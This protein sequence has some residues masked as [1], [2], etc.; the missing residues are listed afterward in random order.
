LLARRA[1]AHGTATPIAPSGQDHL[2]LLAIHQLYTRPEFR[3]SDLHCAIEA[4]RARTLDWDYVF[5]TALSTGIVPAVGCYVQYL[6]R[7]HE[8]VT[9]R[10]L[11]PQPVLD[12]LCRRAR[13]PSA[14]RGRRRTLAFHAPGPQRGCTC[15]T[16]APRS[17]RAAG[18]A[19]A[20]TALS[21]PGAGRSDRRHAEEAGV[22]AKLLRLYHSLPARAARLRPRCVA[23]T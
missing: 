18:Q 14:R 5:A 7:V 17:N 9:G 16:S 10:A 15:K 11:L 4:V 22:N 19:S 6:D 13:D 12:R 20:A 3:L 23:G 21:H 2:L 1:T 8:S